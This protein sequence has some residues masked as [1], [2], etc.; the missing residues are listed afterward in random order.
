MKL[1][2]LVET[3]FGGLILKFPETQLMVRTL[4]NL[5]QVDFLVEKLGVVELDRAVAWVVFYRAVAVM[6]VLVPGQLLPADNPTGMDRLLTCLEEVVVVATRLTQEVLVEEVHYAWCL[7]VTLNLSL[8]S[9][10]WEAA[11]PV[12]LQVELVDPFTLRQTHWNLMKIHSLMF[13]VGSMVEPLGEYTWKVQLLWK[14]LDLIISLLKVE[15]VL[16]LEPV[17][18]FDT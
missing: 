14:T 3:S 15:W 8:Q 2:L 12:D 6:V 7:S 13:R 4:A 9:V 11:A 16:F 17:V 10:H 18:P 1:L 5:A